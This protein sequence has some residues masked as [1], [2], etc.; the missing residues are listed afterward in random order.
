MASAHHS[1][2]PSSRTALPRRTTK[3]PL[4]APTDP[5]SLSATSVPSPQNSTVPLS[6]GKEI[7]EALAVAT[8]AAA[9]RPTAPNVQQEASL[10][11]GLPAS[12]ER[13]LSFL[14][15]ASI[16]H[17]LSQL[18]VP[19]PF[20][21][22]F[23]PPPNAETPLKASMQQLDSLLSQ[24]DFL[25]AAQL[26]G[27]ILVSGTVRP[28]D[29]KS[30]FRLLEIR[31][32][33]LELSGNLLFAA[34]E[35]K[36]LEDLSSGFY[37]DEPNPERGAD[38]D[39]GDGQKVPSHIM[40]FPLRLQAL[41]L[42]SI[43]F[44]DPRRGVSTLYDVGLE[45]REHLSAPSTSSEQRR[46]WTERLREVSIRVVNALIE[47]GDVDCAART[48]ASMKP[49]TDE[50]LALWTS[51][52][53]LLKVKMGDVPGAERLIESGSLGPQD[54]LVLGSLLAIADGRYDDAM[55]SLSENRATANPDLAALVEQNLAVA[56]LYQGEVRKS[57][58]LL[59]RLVNDGQ[60]FQT[61]TINLATV[62]DLTSD[63]SRD[64]KTSMVSQ[65][66][67]HRNDPDHMRVYVNADFKL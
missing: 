14:L 27:S 49:A 42:Q 56:Y 10:A 45:C 16:Y 3:G 35:A 15:D 40:P 65:I 46:L 9:Q 66:A 50:H 1:R 52:M 17:P 43:G 41:R 28:T 7:N 55:E 37:Y 23:L 64:L 11:L 39:L 21:K 62:Y 6:P 44:S 57:R 12:E 47:M 22:P 5:L 2:K 51:R 59:E 26:A 32:S 63:R 48:L 36:A 38:D 34:Q 30:I 4:D 60:S 25:R 31:Y 33:C 24:C 67:G 61:L 29:S 8:G 54:K 13:D 53:I 58:Q 20:R 18:E 19:G